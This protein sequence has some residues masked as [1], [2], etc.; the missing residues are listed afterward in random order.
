[1]VKEEYDTERDAYLMGLELEL[2]V[3]HVSDNDVKKNREGVIAI[4]KHHHGT[5][6][7]KHHPA[8]YGG[9]P[10]KEG[11]LSAAAVAAWEMSYHPADFVKTP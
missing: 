8:A 3:L 5:A 11:N 6:P 9:T 7:P 4:I 10:P 1:M 2:S